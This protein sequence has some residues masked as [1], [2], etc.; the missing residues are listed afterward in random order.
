MSDLTWQLIDQRTMVRRAHSLSPR[1][2]KILTS[3][4]RHTLRRFEAA[5]SNILK[6]R[7]LIEA[8]RLFKR[9]YNH[10]SGRLTN[11]LL[12]ISLKL[13]RRIW[14]YVVPVDPIP[15]RYFSSPIPDDIPTD[16][17]IYTAVWRLRAGRAPGP[18][19][20]KVDDLQR[21]ATQ[22]DRVEWIRLVTCKR[23]L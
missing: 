20:L 10:S 23:V 16:D 18:S 1:E 21:W 4:I 3:R 14:H 7:N 19:G 6:D 9:W 2:L 13:R 22:R 17:E 5:L 11:L 12:L 8:W 15:V